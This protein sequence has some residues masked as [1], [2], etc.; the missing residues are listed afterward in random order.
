MMETV[1]TGTAA[2]IENKLE[3]SFIPYGNIRYSICVQKIIGALFAIAQG[4]TV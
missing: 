2:I 1:H 4:L 3:G